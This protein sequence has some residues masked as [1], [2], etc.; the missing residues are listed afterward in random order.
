M[1]NYRDFRFL[2]TANFCANTAQWFQLLSIGWLVRDLTAASSLSS[3]ALLVVTVGAI[4]TV[5]RLLVGPW[6][7]V[8]GDRLDRRKIVMV[9]MT[10][11]AVAAFGFSMIIR[12]GLVEWWHAYLYVLLAGLVTSVSQ[13]IR[14]ALIANTVPR[15]SFGNAYATNVLTITGTRI[16]GPFIGG[17]LIATL[18][19]AWNF[20]VES[21]LYTATVLSLLPMKTP[22]SQLRETAKVSVFADLKEGIGF[23][24]RGE[25]TIFNLITLGIIPNVVL[26]PTWFLLPLFTVNVLHLGPGVGGI[27]LAAT[28]VG[29]FLSGLVIASVGFVFPKGRLA[30]GM[31]VAS[32]IS[33]IFFAQSHW[34]TLAIIIIG[35]MAFFQAS[36]RTTNGTLIQGLT[37]DVLRGRV[38]SLQSY[39]SGFVIFTSLLIG[40]MV[41]LTNVTFG[42]MTVGAAGLVLSILAIATLKRVRPL[43]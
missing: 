3:S 20:T 23:I 33:V 42:I 6:G 31:V 10:V 40:W 14:Q 39:N 38:T 27:L 22:Y 17:F 26:H 30:L 29:G 7:G 13:P 35:L 32:S 12:L 25:R 34:L 37:P 4:N 8:L 43:A 16:I 19:F 1:K 28:G 18:G 21:A 36:F 24:F 41:D 2:F 15:E 11:M 5:P 9:S